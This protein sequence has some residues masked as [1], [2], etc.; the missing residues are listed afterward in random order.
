MSYISSLT[1]CFGAN[2]NP[3]NYSEDLRKSYFFTV[4]ELYFDHIAY[5]C[6]DVSS[7]NSQRQRPL[8]RTLSQSKKSVLSFQSFFCCCYDCCMC[9]S[10]ILIFAPSLALMLP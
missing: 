7:A 9:V 2:S 10:A 3:F 5:I 4:F 6:T 8:Q 1:S